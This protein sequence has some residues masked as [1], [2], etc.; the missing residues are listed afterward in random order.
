MAV[1]IPDALGEGSVGF[2]ISY[3]AF[4][5][6]LTY[7]WWRTGIYDPDHRPLGT[8]Y[9]L[10]MLIAGL[11]YVASIFVPV[12]WRFYL[13]GI[14]LTICL[15]FPLILVYVTRHNPKARSQL[16]IVMTLSP[17]IVERF[18]LFTIIVLAPQAAGLKSLP[19]I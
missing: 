14:A 7:M 15:I 4:L 2:A 18:G 12:P 17:A 16:K 13:W 19:V 8:P 11:L 6:I 9:S 3:S 1:F 10:L 5:F